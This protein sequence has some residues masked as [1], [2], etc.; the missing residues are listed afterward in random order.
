MIII[1]DDDEAI[2]EWLKTQ[3][4]EINPFSLDNIQRR[5]IYTKQ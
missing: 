5:S 2:M 3:K 4:S 1:Y